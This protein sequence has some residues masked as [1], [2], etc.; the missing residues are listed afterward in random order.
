MFDSF[1]NRVSM[2]SLRTTRAVC[3]TAPWRHPRPTAWTSQFMV[4]HASNSLKDD[5]SRGASIGQAG[6][7]PLEESRG[8]MGV[9]IY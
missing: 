3:T 7:G 9:P 6:M 5:F 1:P 2:S 4:Q 8:V